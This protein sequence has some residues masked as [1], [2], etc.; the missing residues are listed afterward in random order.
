MLPLREFLDNKDDSAEGLRDF[1]GRL[2]TGAGRRGRVLDTLN[3]I[4]ATGADPLKRKFIANTGGSKAHHM[5]NVSPC[6]TRS[7]AGES[8]HW[9]TWK[10][11]Q[12]TRDEVLRL[13][14]VEPS[15]IPRGVIT[16]RQLGLIA[17]NAVTV[18]MLANVM[19]SVFKA[20]G[21][22]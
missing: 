16:E 4:K 15:Q 1:P 5:E 2:P 19:K 7:R 11:R 10:Q 18:P 12:M 21:I 17:G 22:V 9:L 8:G 14:G 13:M 3:A 6:L 20:V